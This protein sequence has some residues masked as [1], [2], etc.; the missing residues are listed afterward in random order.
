VSSD[1]EWAELREVERRFL[2]E[3]PGFAQAFEVRAQQLGRGRAD[4]ST[5][6]IVGVAAALGGLLL[7]LGSLA[8]AVAFVVL[9][10]L[11][12]LVW[13]STDDTR[14]PLPADR[15]DPEPDRP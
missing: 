5:R 14:R 6:V 2:A 8:A 4:R 15:P 13:R 11:V 1:H 3:D 9:T 10:L 7:L 12:G